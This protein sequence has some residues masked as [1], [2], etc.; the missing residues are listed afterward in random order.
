MCADPFLSLYL[1]HFYAGVLIRL[2]RLLA[3]VESFLPRP[4]MPGFPLAGK[5]GSQV[6]GATTHRTHGLRRRKLAPS[7]P[8]EAL[9]PA[10]TRQTD[11]GQYPS[12]RICFLGRDR[13]YGPLSAP[14]E[15]QRSLKKVS[16]KPTEKPSSRLLS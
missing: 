16:I 3:L 1:L 12:K 15:D 2:H 6:T 13:V 10:S 9:R 4:N 11:R 8:Q 5:R 7:G 14:L